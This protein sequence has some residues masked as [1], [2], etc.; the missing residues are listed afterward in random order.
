MV[1]LAIHGGAG[2]DGP[3]K[4]PTDLDPN[5]ITCMQNVLST[6]GTMLES[7]IDALEAVTIAVEML[8]DEPLF[9]AGIGSVLAANGSVTMDA[10]I[11]NGLD[12]AA[13]S[14]VN[15]TNIRHPIRAAKKIL[16]KGWPVMLNSEGAE[17]FAIQ[18]GVERV[19]QDWLITD[20]RKAQWQKW[21]ANN[22]RPGSTDEDD[23]AILDHDGEGLGTVGAVAID[24]KGNLAAA[25]ST[26]G[27]TGKPDGRI[28]DTPIIGAGTWADKTVA[29][30]CTGV[31]E[32]FIR[33]C[34]AHE[35]ST[36][37]KLGD[38][39]AEACEHILDE[40]APLG[41]RG[42]VIA[43][44]NEGNLVMPFQTTLMYRG[45]WVDGEI[46]L[47]IGPELQ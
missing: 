40:V 46:S 1:R 23:E 41:G 25:T 21:K 42:G 36:R 29:V 24:S 19:S 8:E 47:G 39:L 20:L 13:G 43:I 16:E 5:R 4:G 3:W 44:D 15:V 37:L 12:S 7:G 27:M 45:S 30:S 35:V 31:G 14:V 32:A 18:Q 22:S 38:S 10:S 26:G 17:N 2:G 28:G 6:V 34:A 11:M 9:N 33:T